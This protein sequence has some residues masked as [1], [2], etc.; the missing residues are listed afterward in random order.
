MKDE[1]SE[2]QKLDLCIY[3][4]IISLK[5]IIRNSDPESDLADNTLFAACVKRLEVY[6]KAKNLLRWNPK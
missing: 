2:Y 1:L 6:Q 5:S 4:E 3:N